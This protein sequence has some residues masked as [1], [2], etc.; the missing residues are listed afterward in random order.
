[1]MRSFLT[2]LCALTATASPLL[3]QAPPLRPFRADDEKPIPRGVPVRPAEPVTPAATPLQ[4]RRAE[5]V[6]RPKAT[7]TQP[8]EPADP[9]ELRMTP[10][11]GAKSPDQAQ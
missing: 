2:A 7:P 8:I 3:A 1:M 9:G 10:Q 11:A 5:P 6:V 4:I